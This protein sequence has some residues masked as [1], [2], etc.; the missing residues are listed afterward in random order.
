MKTI[1]LIALI[2]VGMVY[3][4]GN[5]HQYLGTA[6]RETLVRWALACETFD[7][8]QRDEIKLGGLHDRL[9]YMTN[10]DLTDYITVLAARYP[11][12]DTKEELDE[13][14]SRFNLDKVRHSLRFL[15]D[16]D[17]VKGLKACS[18]NDKINLALT[19]EQ[20]YREEKNLGKLRGGLHDYISSLSD[21]EIV[22]YIT[23]TTSA[24]PEEFRSVDGL[25]KT[26]AKYGFTYEFEKTEIQNIL[27]KAER[28][29]LIKWALACEK[30]DRVEKE[31]DHI[32]GGL[33]DFISTQKDDEIRK[34]I[35]DKI[36]QYPKLASFNELENISKKYLISNN[37]ELKEF[38]NLLYKTET[39]TLR[40][41]ALAMEIK[42]REG[43][44]QK[45]NEPD[46]KTKID[47]LNREKLVSYVTEYVELHQ[48][49][50]SQIRLVEFVEK[51]GL[52][53]TVI[54]KALDKLLFQASLDQLKIYALTTEKHHRTVNNMGLI[55][56]GL[57]D[58]INQNKI[59]K[60]KLIQYILTEVEEHGEDL[61]TIKKIEDL[62]VQYKIELQPQ[63][64]A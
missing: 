31:Q 4:A 12:L 40:K 53:E 60:E 34:Y 21:D 27:F 56:G 11:Q 57:E 20:I 48:D 36:N 8:R 17:F 55:V 44:K 2:Y 39:E 16:T 54:V 1:I 29:T 13:F 35:E 6:D 33:H 37:F 49:L 62:S 59:T 14:T 32:L 7:N 43:V 42:R 3:T 15:E 9:R 24:L 45:P 52:P 47:A 23:K 30:F 51:Y 58:A 25:K 64:Q 5:L 19:T 50:A 46:A 61:N 41:W 18:R 63:P 38:Q 26:T 10:Q 28:N 22:S